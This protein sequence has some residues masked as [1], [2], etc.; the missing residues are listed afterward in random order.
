MTIQPSS[1]PFSK[2]ELDVI[3]LLLQGKANKEIALALGITERTIESHLGSIYS[4]LGVTSRTSAV[5]KLHEQPMWISTSS[6]DTTHQGNPQLKTD[7]DG[8]ILSPKVRF[9][10]VRSHRFRM[11]NLVRIILVILL[12]ILVVVII[13]AVFAYLRQV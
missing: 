1:N 8:A 3:S 12:A 2:R 7:R 5:I 6:T 10:V 13:T 11:K 4:K 9:L